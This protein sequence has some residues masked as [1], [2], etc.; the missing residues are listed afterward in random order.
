MGFT[1]VT[2]ME[3][4]E[5]FKNK[6][7]FRRGPKGNYVEE[8]IFYALGRT[9]GNR[10]LFIVFIFKRNNEALIISAREMDNKEKSLYSKL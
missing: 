8:N 4:E 3:V 10:L 5:V 1:P 6:P 7:N 9:D 2:V